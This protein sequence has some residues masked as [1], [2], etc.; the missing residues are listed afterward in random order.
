MVKEGY[1]VFFSRITLEDKLGT[2]Y[3]PYIYSALKSSKV[4]LVVGTSKENLESVWVKNEWNRYKKF[5]ETDKDKTLIP[6]YSKI[7]VYQLPNEFTKFQAQNMDKIGA[8]QDLIR[9]I[10]KILNSKNFSNRD[11]DNNAKKLSNGYYEVDVVK[12]KLPL[13]YQELTIFMMIALLIVNVV[14]YFSARGWRALDM[15]IIGMFTSFISWA[16]NVIGIILIFIDRS[17][18]KKSRIRKSFNRKS[19]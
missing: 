9:G 7:D 4:M 12:E 8:M 15:I 6:V 16:I 13:W 17:N 1:K 19:F 11:I 14:N 2:E 3:E 10:K 5:I 18:F